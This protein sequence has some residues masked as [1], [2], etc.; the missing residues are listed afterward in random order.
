M[1]LVCCLLPPFF[2]SERGN[3]RVY[4]VDVSWEGRCCSSRQVRLAC[5]M[6]VLL[7][8]VTDVKWFRAV[9]G[10]IDPVL[11]IFSLQPSLSS[12]TLS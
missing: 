10:K 1:S 11:V 12:P 6:V 3:T 2:Q 9:F 7:Q 4:W 5:G 8:R